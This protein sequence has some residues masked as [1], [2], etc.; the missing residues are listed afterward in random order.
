[1]AWTGSG[2]AS[3]TRTFARTGWQTARRPCRGRSRDDTIAGEYTRLEGDGEADLLE[4]V[5][6]AEVGAVGEEAGAV[7]RS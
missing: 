1:M 4:A 5:C 7:D 2:T 6:L 3:A